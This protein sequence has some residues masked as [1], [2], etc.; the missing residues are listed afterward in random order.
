M[1]L[2]SRSRLGLPIF[3]A[4]VP[5]LWSKKSG[6][7]RPELSSAHMV[8][9][10]SRFHLA[11]PWVLPLL[12]AYHNVKSFNLYQFCSARLFLYKSVTVAA[13]SLWKT[14]I[15]SLSTLWLSIT[16]TLIR[17]DLIIELYRP[18]ECSSLHTEKN[19]FHDRP[20]MQITDQVL[21]K[22]CNSW[23]TSGMPEL[24]G[25]NT[26]STPSC[27]LAMY[28][29]SWEDTDSITSGRRWQRLTSLLHSD[30]MFM[31]RHNIT[32]CG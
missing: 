13:P 14:V 9:S 31:F 30:K 29:S 6:T 28:V 27:T 10:L 19:A 11:A 7:R 32:T 1:G 22:P 3:S 26:E 24:K 12:R 15:V 18:A 21:S 17:R 23:R 4:P 16:Q 25:I 5:C 20:T 8:L 2:L